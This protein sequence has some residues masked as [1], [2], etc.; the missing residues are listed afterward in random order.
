MQFNFIILQ[1][2]LPNQNKFHACYLAQTSSQLNTL[3]NKRRIVITEVTSN[4]P[5]GTNLPSLPHDTDSYKLIKKQ[6]RGLSPSRDRRLSAKLVPTFVDIGVL[7]S[8]QSGSPT[9]V[10]SVS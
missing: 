7:R 6:L 1:R 8:Q 2:T 3:N 9:V 5:F 4:S 10:I